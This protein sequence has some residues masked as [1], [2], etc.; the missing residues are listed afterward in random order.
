MLENTSAQFDSNT[1]FVARFDL[2][3]GER[4]PALLCNDQATLDGELELQIDGDA[5]LAP[6]DSFIVARFASRVGKFAR[7]FIAASASAETGDVRRRSLDADGTWTLTYSATDAI[8]TFDPRDGTAPAVDD[9]STSASD[10]PSAVSDDSAESS[11][12]ISDNNAAVVDDALAAANALC[13]AHPVAVA[14]LSIVL[15]Y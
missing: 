4:A 14:L 11:A 1:Q 13:W 15:V 6:G 7:V 9:K 2:H 8:A 3:S 10:E 12:V 5:A